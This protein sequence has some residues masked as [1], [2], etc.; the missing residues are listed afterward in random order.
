MTITDIMQNM[1]NEDGTFS[2]SDI[3]R[4]SEITGKNKDELFEMYNTESKPNVPDGN[5]S[6]WNREKKLKFIEDNRDAGGFEAYKRLVNER[7]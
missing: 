3:N 4:L 5:P 2:E 1:Q 6:E 7:K